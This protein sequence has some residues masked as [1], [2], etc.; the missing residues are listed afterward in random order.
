MS[1]DDH[2]KIKRGYDSPSTEEL[3][4]KIKDEDISI[5]S[6]DRDFI[7]NISWDTNSNEKE[8]D[9]GD[10]DMGTIDTQNQNQKSSKNYNYL[11]HQYRRLYAENYDEMG[12]LENELKA[13][14]KAK[15][16]LR[17]PVSQSVSPSYSHRS[18]V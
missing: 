15:K 14:E 13:L 9:E 3:V 16:K 17:V 18:S 7:D 11:M 2:S 6:D 5:A 12:D 1:K 4:K 8:S 10:N